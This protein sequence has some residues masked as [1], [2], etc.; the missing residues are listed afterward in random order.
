ME[1]GVALTVLRLRE[2]IAQA[3]ESAYLELERLG[4]WTPGDG[5]LPL[6]TDQLRSGSPRLGNTARV[7]AAE[8]PEDRETRTR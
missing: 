2:R 7:A 8:R 3:Y 1:P 4:V 6:L 5:P